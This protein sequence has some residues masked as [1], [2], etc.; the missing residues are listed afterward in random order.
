MARAEMDRAGLAGWRLEWDYARRR[1]GATRSRDKV[2][3]LSQPLI[4]LYSED[5]V[6]EVIRHEIAHAL[7]GPRHGHDAVWKA[8]ARGLGS[9]GRA[10]LPSDLPRPP[11]AWIGICPNGHRYERYRRPAGG[12][13]CS[14][15]SRQFNPEFLITWQRNAA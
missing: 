13:S 4:K 14:R 6:L 8:A 1:A 10:T 12:A 15:C 9:S 7:V 5:L 3:S 2:I 11:A